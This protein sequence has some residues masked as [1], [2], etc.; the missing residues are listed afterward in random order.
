MVVVMRALLLEHWKGKETSTTNTVQYAAWLS[1]PMLF[2]VVQ[3]WN[4]SFR[5]DF[6]LVFNKSLC[7]MLVQALGA[8]PIDALVPCLLSK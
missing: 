2:D 8:M 5:K 6:M 7:P 1:L 3:A 4:P